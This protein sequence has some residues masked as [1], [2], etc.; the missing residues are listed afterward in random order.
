MSKPSVTA[1]ISPDH[2]WRTDV[3]ALE[4]ER[5]FRPSWL[6]VGFTDDLRNDRDFITARI[7]PHAIVVQNFKGELRA[8]RN[9][10]SHRLSTIQTEP[11]GNRPLTC[12]YHGWSY[13]A[14]G[15]PIGIPANAR[16]FGMDAQDREALALTRY[17]LETCGRFVFVRMVPGGPDLKTF[18][19]RVYDDLSHFSDVCPTR[20]AQNLLEWDVNW[21]VGLEN[22]AEGYH[23]RM[24]HG[25]SLDATLKDELLIEYIEDHSVFYRSLS[26][27]TQIWWEKVS[28]VIRLEASEKFPH[29][30]NYV[31]FPNIVILATYGGSFV[32][33]TFEPVAPTRF[34]FRSTY[35]M[36]KARPGPATDEVF[37]SLAEFSE[38]VMGE[39]HDICTFVQAGVRDVP[40][41]KR[42]VLGA[43]ESRIAHFQQAYARHMYGNQ[44]AEDM[45]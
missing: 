25:D 21:K 34:R 29:S 19:G 20:I 10:C 6:C 26:E 44:T 24:V 7:G 16:A 45:A 14:Q 39:D 11:C 8:F 1:H 33:Q 2:Y 30:T 17:E 36:A 23:T 3:E 5:V 28:R 12:P 35:F 15:V 43:P 32:F 4:M 22:A 13:D 27:K 37:R 9:V 38:R 41:G 18:L 40:A 31:I 42:A